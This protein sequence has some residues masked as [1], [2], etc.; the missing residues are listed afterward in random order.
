MGT[1]PIFE[2][3]FDCLTECT[4]MHDKWREIKAA[5]GQGQT[6][7][8]SKTLVQRLEH[9]CNRGHLSPD[10]W[11][12][13]LR[14]K[15][16]QLARRHGFGV[17]LDH[18][19]LVIGAR[20]GPAQLIQINFD[21]EQFKCGV[22]L[23]GEEMVEC[24]Y[25]AQL[26]KAQDWVAMRR[27]CLLIFALFAPT[28]L[29]HQLQNKFKLLKECE[30]RVNILYVNVSK[31][32]GLS[33]MCVP[34]FQSLSATIT[35]SP[36]DQPQSNSLMLR[37]S[38]PVYINQMALKSCSLVEETV[39]KPDESQLRKL[40]VLTKQR[41]NIKFVGA[42]QFDQPQNIGEIIEALWVWKRISLLVSSW[43]MN[44]RT[45]IYI[46]K[47]GI[48]QSS[49]NGCSIEVSLCKNG[50]AKTYPP[51][52]L[53]TLNY[54]DVHTCINAHNLNSFECVFAAATT[55][56]I[57][58]IKDQQRKSHT[59]ESKSIYAGAMADNPAALNPHLMDILKN[60]H[61][62]KPKHES[63]DQLKFK[64]TNNAKRSSTPSNGSEP[65]AKV[66][67]K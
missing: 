38:E 41:R 46:S 55:E 14:Q 12:G 28:Q 7:P 40:V 42:I 3:D 53:S 57:K 31:R 25:T 35:M 34:I 52:V 56:Y 47:N 33:F 61:P 58:R 23:C 22:I 60:T 17:Q 66:S 9:A 4:N 15:L 62:L 19:V 11:A 27:A 45:F 1:H 43:K 64:E 44:N 13:F 32:N 29:A 24:F 20:Q 21:L 10:Q 37:L 18:H 54:E 16:T 5:I 51:K 26:M 36:A 49:S 8:W 63:A 30:H 6:R 39:V 65:V 48:I 67:K 59:P 50:T 2:S